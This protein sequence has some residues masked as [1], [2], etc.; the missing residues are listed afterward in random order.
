MCEVVAPNQIICKREV[1]PNFLSIKGSDVKG[2]ACKSVYFMYGILLDETKL[3]SEQ[4]VCPFTVFFATPCM[5]I[6]IYIPVTA[7]SNLALFFCPRKL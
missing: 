5:Y 1:D 2:F 4:C 3:A 7:I 6:K